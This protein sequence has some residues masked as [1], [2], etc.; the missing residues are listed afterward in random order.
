[1][2]RE[3]GGA[4]QQLLFGYVRDDFDVRC[5]PLHVILIYVMYDVVVIEL[6]VHVSYYFGSMLGLIC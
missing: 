6:S 3:R 5:H 4:A 2:H 1:M